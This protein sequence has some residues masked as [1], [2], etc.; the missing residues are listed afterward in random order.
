ML[1]WLSDLIIGIE[2][3]KYSSNAWDSQMITIYP[4]N[5]IMQTATYSTQETHFFKDLMSIQ[6]G[7][8]REFSSLHIVKHEC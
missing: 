2:V 3:T 5:L 6:G 8:N 1:E 4:E 7:Q